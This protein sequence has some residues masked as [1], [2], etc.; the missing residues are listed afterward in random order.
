MVQTKPNGFKMWGLQL[1]VEWNEDFEEPL[2]AAHDPPTSH[3][4]PPSWHQ[5]L[6]RPTSKVVFSILPSVGTQYDR[7]I[8]HSTASKSQLSEMT[9]Y[10]RARGLQSADGLSILYLWSVLMAN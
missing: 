1:Q 4:T 10:P 8:Y 5:H 6:P 2:E 9:M 3:G 7:H